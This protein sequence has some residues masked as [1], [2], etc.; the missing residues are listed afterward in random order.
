VR[1]PRA[2]GGAW[3]IE[4]QHAKGKLTARERLDENAFEESTC[5]SNT[6]ARTSGWRTS[7]SGSLT[8]AND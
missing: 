1:R 8:F 5:S 4:S 6:A 7:A 3:R 2:G